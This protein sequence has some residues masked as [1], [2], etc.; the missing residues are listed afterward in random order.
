[1]GTGFPVANQREALARRSCSKKRIDTA[2]QKSPQRL[3]RCGLSI[4]AM[5]Q[6][7]AGDLPDVSNF[8]EN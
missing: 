4:F 5:M 6:P 8:I 3:S 2:W 7:Y 1:M